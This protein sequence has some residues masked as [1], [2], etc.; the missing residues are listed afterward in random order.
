MTDTGPGGTAGGLQWGSAVDGRRVYTANANSNAKPYLGSTD[1]IW[2]A[3]DAASGRIVWQSRPSGGGGTSG[4]VTA[5]NGVVF[6]CSLDPSGRM[7][8]LDAA[9][10]TE[11][12]SFASGG[13]C[14]S[15]AAV[16]NG[17]VYWGSGYANLGGTPN[18]KLFAFA[19]K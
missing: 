10:G 6:G 17:T 5:A 1:G 19:L 4:P 11:L 15:G 7:Y 12:W 13:S 18:N 3:L 16:S 14:L 2:T 8:A 9:T